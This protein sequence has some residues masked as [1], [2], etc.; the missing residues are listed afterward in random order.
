MTSQEVYDLLSVP[1]IQLKELKA[2]VDVIM[3]IHKSIPEEE[4]RWLLNKANDV[5][6]EVVARD[7][8]L[9]DLKRRAKENKSKRKA[10][11]PADDRYTDYTQSE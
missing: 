1:D 3:A 8:A 5:M 7:S 11:P 10:L 2:L 9:D 6:M 4:G